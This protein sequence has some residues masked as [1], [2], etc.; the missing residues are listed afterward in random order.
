MDGFAMV[1]SF[2]EAGYHETR[3]VLMILALTISLFFA[4]KKDDKNYIVIFLSSTIFFA[5]V[6][7]IMLI[8]GLRAEAWRISVFGVI[9]PPY[10][11]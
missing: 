5:I 6:E 9:I 3:I 2:D 1:R 4:L 11:S 7:L 10:I 8:V